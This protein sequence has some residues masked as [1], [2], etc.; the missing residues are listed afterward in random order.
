MFMTMIG[1]LV[2]SALLL[3]VLTL[4][5][6][7]FGRALGLG[8]HPLRLMLAPPVLV[9]VLAL[10]LVL[11]VMMGVPLHH[12]APYIWAALGAS[13]FYG[14]LSSR[15][16]LA[17]GTWRPIVLTAFGVSALVLGGFE[18]HGLS[19]YL[20]SPN[21]DGFTYVAFG[22]YLRQFPRGTEGGLAPLYQYGSHL[23]ASPLT[24]WQQR[25]W[26]CSFRPGRRW[27]RR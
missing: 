4:S 23:S 7:G 13:A 24:P 19:T 1:N 26:R 3:A 20:G 12:V 17:D 9:A 2:V 15:A 5:G 14:A 6:I 21:Q 8:N 25:A 11:C 18:W 27:T 10:M 22:E 16:L